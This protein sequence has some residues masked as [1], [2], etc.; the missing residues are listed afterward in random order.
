MD[1]PVNIHDVYVK[2]IK[3]TASYKLICR[4]M[5]SMS[6]GMEWAG[7]GE[8]IG[9]IDH[10]SLQT[11]GI[12][13]VKS[14][15]KLSKTDFEL[16]F[17]EDIPAN[18]VVNNGLENLTWT[19]SATI[20]NS[21]LESC[22]ARGI[23]VTTPKQVIIENNSFRSSGSAILIA[24]DV[25]SWYESGAV[26]DVLISKNTF[27][28]SCMTSNYQFSEAIIS[29]YPEVHLFD[30]ITPPY[31][32]NIQITHNEFHPYDYPLVFAQSVSGLKFENNTLVRSYDYKPFHS[33]KATFTLIG[34][35]DVTIKKNQVGSDILGK[36]VIM[37]FMKRSDVK[38]QKEFILEN[39]PD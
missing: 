36:N 3:K 4:F 8:S 15:Q 29:I 11:K 12:T 38:L 10:H 9:F 7:P 30:K 2:I 35:R 39:R 16:T 13:I 20:T 1:D 18:V 32:R 19:P 37:M 5:E 26:K 17:N 31:H 21:V 23:L 6:V 34:S 14:V 27:E 28:S 24:G 22:R 25:N 33:R